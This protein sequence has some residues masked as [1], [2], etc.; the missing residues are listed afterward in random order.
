METFSN[1][2]VGIIKFHPSLLERLST[3]PVFIHP[4]LL[5]MLVKPRPWVTRNTGGYLNYNSDVVRVSQNPEH[6]AYVKAADER[7]HLSLVYESLDVLGSTAWTINEQVYD[8]MRQLWN[9]GEAIADLPPAELP[10]P[11]PHPENWDGMS[12]EEK[13]AFLQKK[14]KMEADRRNAFSQRCDTNYKIEI[15]RAVSI[16]S[17]PLY[18]YK[19]I[20][21][22]TLPR[23]CN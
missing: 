8:V 12:I 17:F 6:L 10:T 16:S 9:S 2:R 1:K 18:P 14:K 5:P 21:M 3:E 13:R 22:L 20:G 4:R 15:A 11:P 19:H 23:L 7:G